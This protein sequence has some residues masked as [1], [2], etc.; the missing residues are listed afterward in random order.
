[1]TKFWGWSF[2]QAVVGKEQNEGEGVSP[3]IQLQKSDEILVFVRQGNLSC[4]MCHIN[5][6]CSAEPDLQHILEVNFGL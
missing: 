2:F 1:M 4:P 3:I 5:W 6:F